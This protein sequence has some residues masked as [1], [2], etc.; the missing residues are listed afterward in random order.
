MTAGSQQ[1]ERRLEPDRGEP[2]QQRGP[3]D[4]RLEE[5]HRADRAGRDLR[6]GARSR[7]LRRLDRPEPGLRGRVA[8]KALEDGEISGYPEY[9]STALT[10]FFKTAPEDVPAD[11][12]EAIDQA[13]PEFEEKGLVAFAPTGVLERERGRPARPRPPTSSASRASRT[14]RAS[15]EDLD[16]YGSPECPQRIDCL[17]RARGELRARRSIRSRRSTSACATR[18][19]TRA[20]RICRSCSRPTPSSTP[21]PTPT[22]SWR[23]TRACCRR[24][25]QLRRQPGGG[26]RGRAGLRRDRREGPG[27]PLRSR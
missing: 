9:T 17:R 21:T 20:T 19:W 11:G 2:R 24:Q 4:G 18:C 27:R 25:R 5:L 23:T 14:S 16:L 8:L 1:R 13:Q 6:A 7:G 22:R 15:P 26:R 12:Q 3:A 10:S